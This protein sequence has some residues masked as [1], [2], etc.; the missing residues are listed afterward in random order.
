LA[1]RP[2]GGGAQGRPRFAMLAASSARRGSSSRRH[3]VSPRRFTT[4]T[5]AQGHGGSPQCRSSSAS[6]VSSRRLLMARGGGGS[7]ARGGDGS[8]LILHEVQRPA[9]G[10]PRGCGILRS[11][12]PMATSPHCYSTEGQGVRSSGGA[13]TWQVAATGCDARSGARESCS[14]QRASSESCS[15]SSSSIAPFFFSLSSP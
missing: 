9:R 14:G 1:A 13:A 3:E 11:C 7:G 12:S 8:E 2:P 10:K 15:Q 6:F 4:A 5:Q